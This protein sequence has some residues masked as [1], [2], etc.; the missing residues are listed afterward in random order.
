M[1]YF[2]DALKGMSWMGGLRVSVRGITFLKLAI[3]ARLL[4]PTQFG[5]FGIATLVLAFLEIFTETGINIF[6]IQENEDLKKYVNTSWVVSIARGTLMSLILLVASS[7]ISS[8]FHAPDSYRLILLISLVPFV[9]GFINPSIVKFQKELLFNKEFYLRFAIYFLDAFVA[10]VV[11]LVTKSAISLVWGM[12]AGALL[13]VAL[14]HLIIKPRPKLDFDKKKL[15][16]VVNRGKW[17][18]AAGI[19]DYLFEN[20]D[21]IVVGRILNAGNLG[22]YQMAY[23]ISSIPITEVADVVKKVTFPVYV[24]IAGD[25]ER[26]KRA[27]LKTIFFVGVVALFSGILLYLFADVFVKVVLG[28]NWLAIVP[29][30]KV[31][32]F[33]GVVRALLEATYP[34][35]LSVKKQEYITAITFIGIIALSVTIYPLVKSFGI[36][37]AGISALIGALVTLP[38]AYYYSARSFRNLK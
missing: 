31:L 25:T 14:S 35:F 24:K 6:L 19:F 16:K 20:V 8:F 32:S 17:V 15:L 13:E 2:R 1:G 30:I 28:P 3:L 5:L 23:K 34:F 4:T 18:T 9:R 29:A 26:L 12:L 38:T 33:F 37:G 10:I 36:V 22:L 21:D 7:L 27:Y 11:A